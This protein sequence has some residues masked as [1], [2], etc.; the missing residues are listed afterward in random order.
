MWGRFLQVFLLDYPAILQSD[1]AVR[2]IA[3]RRVIGDDGGVGVRA[4]KV[5]I[6]LNSYWVI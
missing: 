5:E 1:G 3:E 2:L 6:F 4:G